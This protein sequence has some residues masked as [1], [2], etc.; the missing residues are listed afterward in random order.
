VSEAWNRVRADAA[1]LAHLLT[2]PAPYPAIAAEPG[3]P[4]GYL[5]GRGRSLRDRLTARVHELMKTYDWSEA[6]GQAAVDLLGRTSDDRPTDPPA[7]P[8]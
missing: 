6:R 1:L 3:L 4:E 2:P 5:H 7:D 8:V